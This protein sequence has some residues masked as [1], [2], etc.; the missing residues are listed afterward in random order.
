M[1]TYR[2]LPSSEVGMHGLRT[3]GN[4]AL[5]AAGTRRSRPGE[6]HGELERRGG[7]SPPLTRHT[8][9][10]SPCYTLQQ[11]CNGANRSTNSI[12]GR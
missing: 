10:P 6:A 2:Q 7:E 8:E 12:G 5:A 11:P 9:R 3:S 1:T 4:T